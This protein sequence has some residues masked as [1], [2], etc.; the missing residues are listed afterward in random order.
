MQANLKKLEVGFE[1]LSRPMGGPQSPEN[2]SGS[3]LVS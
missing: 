3:Q 2:Q 1:A